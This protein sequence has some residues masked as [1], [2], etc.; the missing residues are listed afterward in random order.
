M[1]VLFYVAQAALTVVYAAGLVCEWLA[2]AVI[3]VGMTI[4]E[5]IANGCQ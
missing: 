1:A 5:F 4:C 2:L 3:Y